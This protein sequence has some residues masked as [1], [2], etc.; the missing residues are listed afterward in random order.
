MALRRQD[1]SDEEEVS[2]SEHEFFSDSE[3]SDA[4]RLC[5]HYLGDSPQLCA[6]LDVFQADQI[7]VSA[8]L[9][10]G[11]VPEYAEVW[12]HRL[13]GDSGD[14]KPYRCIDL[15]LNLPLAEIAVHT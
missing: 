6:L 4:E 10:L 1:A 13:S 8:A 9:A 7:K 11:L 3:G 14:L 2:E 15:C 5:K 12:R